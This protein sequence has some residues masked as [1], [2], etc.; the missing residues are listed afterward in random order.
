MTKAVDQGTGKT[1]RLDS[2]FRFQDIEHGSQLLLVFD[3]NVNVLHAFVCS[4]W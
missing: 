4:P 1:V 2:G 3:Y